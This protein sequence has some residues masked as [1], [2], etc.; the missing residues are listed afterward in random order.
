M[1]LKAAFMFLAEGADPQ[2]HRSVVQTPQVE[3]ITVGVATYAAAQK[4]AQA[5]VQEGVVAIELC[6]GFG[7]VGT[8]H[9]VEAVQ[10][11][12]AIGVVR[13]DGHPGLQGRSG[14][15]LFGAA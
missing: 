11:R 14:D 4:A 2:V 15:L 8:A 5:L 13:F 10:G 1:S 3:L 9:I 6:G 7:H 12:A